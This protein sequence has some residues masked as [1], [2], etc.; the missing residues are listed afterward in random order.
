VS[1]ATPLTDLVSDLSQRIRVAQGILLD[2]T[3]G[4]REV[5]VEELWRALAALDGQNG[6][7][8]PA[9]PAVSSADNPGLVADGRSRPGRH[10]G[11]RR[12]V[13]ELC[14]AAQRLIRSIG[15]RT[16]ES[17]PEDLVHLIGLRSVLTE[18]IDTAA[19]GIRQ[20]RSASEI[21]A[22]LGISQPAVSK[23]W[24]KGGRRWL[25]TRT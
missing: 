20:T 19:L 15:L 6:V 25:R 18:A 10:P 5:P 17:D 13:S 24:P 2:A 9:E 14:E 1:N 11:A 22:A 23:R 4:R 21:A 12:E 16:A 7:P 3:R 8:I